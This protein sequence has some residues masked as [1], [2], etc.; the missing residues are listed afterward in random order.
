[1]KVVMGSMNGVRLLDLMNAATNRCSRVTAAV[2]YAANN[3]PFF[4]HCLQNKIFLDYFGLLDEDEAVAIAVLQKLVEAGPLASNCR[5]IKGH[6]HSKIIWWHGFGAYIGSANLTAAAWTTNVECGVFY[7]ESEIVGTQLQVDLEQQFDYLRVSSS[8]VTSELVKAL[9]SIRPYEEA[10]QRAKN[11]ARS[12][13]ELAT[14]GIS[15]HAGLASYGP[16][17]RTTAFTRF[18][19]EWSETLELLRGLSRDFQKLNLRPKWVAPDAEPAVHFDQF[20]HA[21][22]YVRIRDEKQDE[23]SAKSVELVNRAYL[24]HRDNPGLALEDAAKWWSS[25]PEAP[26]GEDVFIREA[27]PRIRASFAKENLAS[28]KLEDFQR[29]FF[30]V[31]AFKTHARQVKNSFLGLPQ[32]H[33]E[34][35]I[36]RSDRLAT[37]LWEQKR[38]SDQKSVLDLLNFL[39]WGT[40]PENAVERLW[41]V[42]TDGKWRFDHLGPSSL[43][44]ALGWARPDQY[45]PRN[46]RTNKALR[47]LG[48]DVRLFSD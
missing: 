30:E 24:N 26:Y 40:N 36:E 16:S 1:M 48:H 33:R 35:A 3:T 38:E 9:R 13:F 37:W 2:A 42:T 19:A 25:L 12:Q 22:Y 14:K 34:S 29:T 44:E 46:N 7:D 31:H 43:G 41:M 20:L 21:Y 18:T 15:P 47:S 4:E 39:F 28:W 8:P 23:D 32:G 10:V 5:L 6:F 11:Q 45:P 17:I 27:A